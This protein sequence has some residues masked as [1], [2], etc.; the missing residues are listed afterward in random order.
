MVS[1][2]WL[3]DILKAI[4]TASFNTASPNTIIN[5][6][7]VTLSCLKIDIVATGSIA[8]MKHPNYKL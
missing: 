6:N 2:T 1:D 4:A 5:S 3:T 7:S 8:E